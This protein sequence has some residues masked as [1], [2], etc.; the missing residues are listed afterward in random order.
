[1]VFWSDHVDLTNKQV[2]ARLLGNIRTRNCLLCGLEPASLE[3]L[4]RTFQ[5]YALPYPLLII[6]ITFNWFGYLPSSQ[7]NW[8]HLI[9][10]TTECRPKLT[11]LVSLA[12]SADSADVDKRITSYDWRLIDL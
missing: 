7:Q 2:P 9:L 5:V 1:M 12:G 8:I 10:S 4:T 11:Y 6:A 3:S